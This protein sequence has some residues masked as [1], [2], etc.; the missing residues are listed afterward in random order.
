MNFKKNYFLDVKK[1]SKYN[2]S[3]Q[4]LYERFNFDF[5]PSFARFLKSCFFTLLSLIGILISKYRNL[6]KA[7]YFIIPWRCKYPYIDKRSQETFK[8]IGRD[9]TFNLVKSVSASNSLK[10]F[11]LHPNSIFFYEILDVI[12]FFNY[13][14]NENVKENCKSFHACNKKFEKLIQKLFKFLNIQKLINH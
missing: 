8:I 13:K 2:I 3:K 10:F 7:H 6:N 11:L 1:N 5:S 14:Y 4:I 9:K 12:L